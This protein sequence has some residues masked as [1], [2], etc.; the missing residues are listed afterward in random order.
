LLADLD[1]MDVENGKL[2]KIQDLLVG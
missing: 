2:H 1:L